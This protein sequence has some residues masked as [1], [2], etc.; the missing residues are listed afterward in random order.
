MYGKVKRDAVEIIK[1]LCA[2]K[3]VEFP[4]RK[5]E[6]KTRDE[7]DENK[8]RRKQETKTRDLDHAYLA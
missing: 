3:N 2:M 7:N 4:T 6:T 1:K 5:Q 8:R